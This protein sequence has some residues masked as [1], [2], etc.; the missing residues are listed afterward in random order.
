MLT[1]CQ[2]ATPIDVV[3]TR[4]QVDDGLKGQNMVRAGRSM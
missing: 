3:K 1:E 2:A 4:I